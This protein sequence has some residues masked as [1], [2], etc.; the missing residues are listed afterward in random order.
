MKRD[1]SVAGYISGT[2]FLYLLN[3]QKY[4]IKK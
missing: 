2:A 1:N 4:Q 3:D